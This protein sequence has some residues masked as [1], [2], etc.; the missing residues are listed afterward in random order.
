M[1]FS[2]R[3][4][5]VLVSCVM[6]YTTAYLNRLNLSAVLGTLTVKAG[7][8]VLVQVPLV[9]AEAVERLRWSDLMVTVLRKICMAAEPAA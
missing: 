9:A 5:W 3:Q 1:R 6:I 2:R 8:Q 4:T 7:E